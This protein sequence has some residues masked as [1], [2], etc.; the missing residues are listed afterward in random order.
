MELLRPIQD[1]Y[2]NSS[3]WQEVTNKG[4]PPAEVKKKEKKVKNLGTRFPGNKSGVEAKPDGHI[5]GAQKDQVNL[6][7]GA[8]EAMNN[9]DIKPKDDP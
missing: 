5:E 4:Y 9:L 8:E 2:K 6:G 7:T 1:D 3:S